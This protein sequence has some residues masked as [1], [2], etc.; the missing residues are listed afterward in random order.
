AY[1]PQ[2]LDAT[3]HATVNSAKGLIT[4]I[5]NPIFDESE[6]VMCPEPT[7][8]AKI[9]AINSL[10]QQ[11][12]NKDAMTLCR[13]FGQKCIAVPGKWGCGYFDNDEKN[14]RG[15][16]FRP[17]SDYP[18]IPSITFDDEEKMRHESGG[19]YYQE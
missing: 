10:C 14:S 19:F 8:K 11:K 16:L 15:C 13:Y 2:N 1:N 4:S 17:V 18:G 9:I 7:F 3:V 12:F 5:L 6:G